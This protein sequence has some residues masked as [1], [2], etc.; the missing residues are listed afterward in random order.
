MQ[1]N[2]KLGI[3]F[4][5]EDVEMNFFKY[6][7]KYYKHMYVMGYGMLVAIPAL[8]VVAYMVLLTAAAIHLY[9]N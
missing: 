2:D 7:S 6:L 5:E 4:I 3:S 9:S 8:H 1:G